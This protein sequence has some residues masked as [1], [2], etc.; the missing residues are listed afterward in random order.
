MILTIPLQPLNMK[1]IG[2][3]PLLLY[4]FKVTSLLA[5][6][7][8]VESPG[9]GYGL[10]DKVS[11][12]RLDNDPY[13]NE[14]DVKFRIINWRGEGVEGDKKWAGAVG[15]GIGGTVGYLVGA[16]CGGS[17]VTGPGGAALGGYIGG[18]LG[19]GY[20]GWFDHTIYFYC[21]EEGEVQKGDIYNHDTD[22]DNDLYWI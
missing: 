16:S 9:G 15:A 14:N 5:T 8:A 22:G 12:E 4:Y 11:T 13:I 1:K 18:W 10:L 6:E 7:A 17:A 3:C 21:S 19:S 20:V 2:D